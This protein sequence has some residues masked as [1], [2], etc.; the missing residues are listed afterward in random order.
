MGLEQNARDIENEQATIDR[1][2]S[3][4]RVIC[5]LALVVVL[6]AGLA[7]WLNSGRP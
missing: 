1:T 4:A 2:T 3:L 5:I 6:I 7:A